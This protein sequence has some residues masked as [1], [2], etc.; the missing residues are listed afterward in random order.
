M[1]SNEFLGGGY[2]SLQTQRKEDNMGDMEKMAQREL[3]SSPLT[4]NLDEVDSDNLMDKAW[5]HEPA[6]HDKRDGTV[7]WLHTL[8][9]R[10]ESVRHMW[11]M[12]APSRLKVIVPRAPL[13]PI[14]ALA[15]KETRAWFDYEVATMKE[16][17]EEDYRNIENTARSLKWLL[18]EECKK[19]D[20]R[21][22]IVAGFGQGGAMAINV[23]LSYA[24]PLG[25]ILSFSGFVPLMENYPDEISEANKKT[26]VLAIHGNSDKVVPIEFAKKRYETLKKF[27][28][29]YE[30]RAHF[31]LEHNTSEETLFSMQQWFTEVLTRK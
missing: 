29:D 15:E 11:E 1:T 28:I 24:K 8:G 16:G 27:G 7:I 23:G 31:Y 17:M 20:S 26:P 5:V 25:G 14:T 13:L 19:E 10:F 21:K 4:D 3:F 2:K 30:M 6:S 22:I 18:D 9:D 12:L